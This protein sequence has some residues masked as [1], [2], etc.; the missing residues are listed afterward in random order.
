[1]TLLHARVARPARRIE[2]VSPLAAVLFSGLCWLVF[3]VLHG[4]RS[5][6]TLPELTRQF[7][8]AQR[9]WLAAAVLGIGLSVFAGMHGADSGWTRVARIYAVI[10]AAL[11]VFNIGWGIIAIY[12]L[13]LPSGAL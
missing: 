11:S 10:L 4:D 2:V 13:I 9:W 12:V 3:T 6:G 1:M 7:L 8:V 5:A